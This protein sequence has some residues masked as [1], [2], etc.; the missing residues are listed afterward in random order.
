MKFEHFLF[1]A[2]L[3]MAA[4][5]AYFSIIGISSLFSGA[6][7]SAVIMAFIIEFSKIVG[8][9]FL[10]RYWTKTNKLIK[11]Y[12]CV[13]SVILMII[14]SFGIAG[15]LLSAYNKSSIEFK[16]NQEKITMV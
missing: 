12:M 13:A 8:V 6:F 10:Y 7:I 5:G 1:I 14:T 2:A 15:F 3:G 9:T 4:C 11:N 16:A